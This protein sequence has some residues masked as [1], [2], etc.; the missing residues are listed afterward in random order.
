[1]TVDI[2]F[3]GKIADKTGSRRM[4]IDL[5]ETG[6]RLF[7]LRDA[8]L[9]ALFEEGGLDAALVQMSVNQVRVTGDTTLSDGDEVAFFSAFSGG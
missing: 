4:Q 9:G 3:F 6:G 7:A 8:V 5:M 2:L 1:M